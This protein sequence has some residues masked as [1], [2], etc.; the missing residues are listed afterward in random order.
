MDLDFAPDMMCQKALKT[1]LKSSTL[2]HV[3]IV[4]P[5]M[6]GDLLNAL[7]R[8]I[9][10]LRIPPSVGRPPYWVLMV[11]MWRRAELPLIQ[12][13][14]LV[15]EAQSSTLSAQVHDILGN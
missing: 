10:I 13:L 15:G 11:L 3:D 14:H 8:S 2:R 9:E 12:E 7:P 1:F 5:R 4:W 6:G